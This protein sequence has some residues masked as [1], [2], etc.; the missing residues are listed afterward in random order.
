MLREAVDTVDE[1]IVAGIETLRRLRA[2]AST[3]VEAQ[4]R[5]KHRG[6]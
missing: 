4:D 6:S 2:T 1:R 3:C 5:G